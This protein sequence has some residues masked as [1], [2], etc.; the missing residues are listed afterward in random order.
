MMQVQN[1]RSPK[2]V[3]IVAPAYNEEETILHLY[4]RVCGV[5]EG[6]GWNFELIIVE[7]GSVDRSLEILKELHGKDN[8]ANFVSLSRN[9]GH[10][11]GL[12][13][14]LEHSR[15]DVI[16]TM[17][18]DLQHP[19][20]LI[21]EMLGLWSEGYDIVYTTKREVASQSFVRRLFNRVFYASMSRL[22]GLE[23][24][25]GQSDF[26]LMDRKAVDALKS[27]PERNKFLRG[28]TRWIGFRQVGIDY[29]V[30]PRFAGRSKFRFAHLIRFALDGILS[31]SILPLRL[32]TLLGAVISLLAFVYGLYILIQGMYAFM[33]GYHGRIPPG[34]ATVGA[35][36][37]F[38]GGVQLLGIG[39]LGEYLGRV[40]D[41]VKERPVF[42]V[43]E[44]SLDFKE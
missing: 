37:F 3:S 21:P 10:Q 17:D 36:I 33:T 22:S 35:A 20:E 31:F 9:F 4:E 24:S 13:A 19:P 41:E 28:L 27:M 2:L 26:R 18:A 38:F 43:Q 29:D 32:F 40:Y 7:N 39:L 23:L 1:R 11:G 12:I 16:I 44:H 25:G 42:L 34:W 15:G 8:R 14:G 5:M 30:P 6:A